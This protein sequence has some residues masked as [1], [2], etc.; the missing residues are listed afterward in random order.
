MKF[1]IVT[2]SYNNG[3]NIL[4]CL[5]SVAIQDGDFE[6]EH[7]IVD[8]GSTDSTLKILQT[9]KALTLSKKVGGK[10]YSLS[11]ISEPDD[12]MYDAIVKGFQNANGD[13]LAWINT[14]DYYLPGAFQAISDAFEKERVKWVTGISDTE[15]ID[16]SFRLGRL[17]EYRRGL[18]KKGAYGTVLDYIRQES[19]F[20]TKELW[21]K[22]NPNVLV[23]YK[24]AGDFR[25][26]QLFSSYENLYSLDYHVAVFKKRPGQKSANQYEYFNEA[27][28]TVYISETE[29]LLLK[30][31]KKVETLFRI[32]LIR[33]PRINGE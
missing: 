9:F 21:N 1:Y 23:D 25:L 26:W 6:I 28:K 4:R 30:L 20:W 18:I 3:E 27:N 14:D 11:W 29:K 33:G 15:N 22:I 13:I 5:E 32:Y 7:V 31:I 8:G 19:V 16:G 17:R 2:P 24:Y 10:K 12:G